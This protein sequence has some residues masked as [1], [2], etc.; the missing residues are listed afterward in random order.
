MKIATIVVAIAVLFIASTIYTQQNKKL[1]THLVEFTA[2]FVFGRFNLPENNPLTQES[3]LLGRRL[4]YDPILSSNNQVSCATCHKQALAF[5]DGLKTSV[6]ISGNP[7]AFNSMSLVNLM[8]GPR[9]FFWD[10]R[11]SS[12]EEQAIHPIAHVDEM[13]RNIEELIVDLNNDETYKKLFKQA[14]GNISEQNIAKALANFQRTLISAN[15]RY[16]QYLRG[17]ISLTAKEEQGRKLFMAH[18]DTKVVLRGG[19]CIDCH[20]QFLTSGFGTAFDGFSNNG[21]DDDQTL[22]PGLFTLTNNE[23]HRGLFKAPT[24]RN[25]AVTSPYMHDGRFATLQEVLA[26]YNG[27]IKRSKTLSPLIIEADN[28]AKTQ[29]DHISLN[30]NDNEITAIIAFLHTLTDE[31]FLANRAFSSPF[32]AENNDDD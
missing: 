6:G 2:P 26:H 29:S 25:I 9:H 21:L 20:S 31:K 28:I 19:N 10:G 23:M 7:L 17:E 30:L 32:M 4:F 13:A 12:L 15:S 16:D 3:V 5:T 1:D 18:P 14:F 24:L 27:G 22:Q 11:V 8:W